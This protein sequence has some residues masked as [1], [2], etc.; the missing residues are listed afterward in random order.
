MKESDV[1]FILE[2]LQIQWADFTQYMRGQ[3]LSE[4]LEGNTI[5]WLDD[6]KRFLCQQLCDKEY[7]DFD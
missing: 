6:V 3:T 1:K 5:Y 4:D 7:Q 2:K